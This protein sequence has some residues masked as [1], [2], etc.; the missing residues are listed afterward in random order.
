M[1]SDEQSASLPNKKIART[2]GVSFFRFR[3]QITGCTGVSYAVFRIGAGSADFVFIFSGRQHE[4]GD[5]ERRD[6]PRREMNAS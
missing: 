6:Q 5:R 1:V 2:E 3:F 4:A